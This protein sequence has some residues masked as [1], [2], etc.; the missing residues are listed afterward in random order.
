MSFPD[1]AA[2]ISASDIALYGDVA[3]GIF[4]ADLPQARDGIDVCDFVKLDVVACRRTNQEVLYRVDILA[5]GL[6]K[7]GSNAEDFFT[8][9][10][11]ADF[12]TS[13]CTMDCM[14]YL[15][16]A[17]AVAISALQM[18]EIASLRSQ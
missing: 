5:I 2:G 16:V 18:S 9:K 12:L 3:A 10:D 11:L 13:Y 14:L 8:L 7:S 1:K 15:V 6:G 17:Q 4:A